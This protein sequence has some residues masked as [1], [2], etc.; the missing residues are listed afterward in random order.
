M[1]TQAESVVDPLGIPD[2]VVVLG[3]PDLQSY[4]DANRWNRLRE[5][6]LIALVGWLPQPVGTLLRRY[7]Y[8]FIL[9]GCGRAISIHGTGVEFVGGNNIELED[10]VK[11][12]RDVRVNAF[13]Q[14]SHI[15]L[16]SGVYLYRDV[17]V[18]VTYLGNCTINIGANS[19]I[20]AFTCIHGPGNIRIGESCLIAS[21]VGIYAN[22]HIFAD[23]TQRIIDQGVTRE[24]I[25]IEDDCW[26]ATGVTILDGVM[27]GQGCVIGAGAV[28]T[29]SIPPYSVA[30][31]VP[32][33]VVSSRKPMNK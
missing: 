17:D 20:G 9:K 30:V 19:V 2:K 12:M 14:G 13:A 4:Q 5:L 15:H 32:A 28:V 6:G 25:V 11:I 8:R 21:H 33:K 22:N 27:I 10:G 29:K 16:K 7:L 1:H 31:G 18:S 24:G 3:N 26:I 23:P